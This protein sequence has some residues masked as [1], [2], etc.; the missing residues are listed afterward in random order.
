M[1]STVDQL[2]RLAKLSPDKRELLFKALSEKAVRKAPQR[3]PRRDQLD[4]IPVS[5]A[6]ARLWFIDQMSAGSSAYNVPA[7]IRLKGPLNLV[8]FEHSIREVMRRHEILRTTFGVF[9]EEPEQ[10]I[11]DNVALD[12][13]Y[14]DLRG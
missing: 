13:T 12:L 5:Y 1:Q 10:V 2:N 3:I 9:G 7:V 11:A 14:C 8:A 6:Q 4:H